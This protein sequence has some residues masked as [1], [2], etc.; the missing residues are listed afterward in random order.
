MPAW[1]YQLLGVDEARKWLQRNYLAQTVSQGTNS[2]LID[3]LRSVRVTQS[4]ERH[5]QHLPHPP[6]MVRSKVSQGLQ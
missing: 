2:H 3:Q 5:W 1:Q 6:T 4:L